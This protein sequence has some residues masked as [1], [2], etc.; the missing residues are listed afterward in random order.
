MKYI[1]TISYC[2]SSEIEVD[3]DCEKAAEGLA[4][5]QLCD[6]QI[7]RDVM[8]DTESVERADGEED[9]DDDGETDTDEFKIPEEA[10]PSKWSSLVDLESWTD[11]ETVSPARSERQV[12]TR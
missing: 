11:F 6:D 12:A 4:Y 7:F 8:L 1:V 9:D 5:D 10:F 3:A 2:G